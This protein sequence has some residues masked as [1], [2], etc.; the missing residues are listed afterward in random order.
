M[1]SDACRQMLVDGMR[2]IHAATDYRRLRVAQLLTETADPMLD[3]HR[4]VCASLSPEA[5]LSLVLQA[6]AHGVLPAVARNLSTLFAA[7]DFATVRAES[8]RRWREAAVHTIML[9]QLAETIL[10]D[11]HGLPVTIVKGRAFAEDIYPHASLRG[12]TD[13]D[14]LAAPA[15]LEPLAEILRQHG[16]RFADWDHDPARQEFKW[17]RGDDH[18]L[19][20]EIHTNVVHHPE[21]RQSLSLT[22]DDIETMPRAPAAHL[23]VA[24]LHG[25]LHQ[26]ERL[27]QVVDILQAARALATAADEVQFERLVVR[28]GGRLAAVAGLQ[29]A[30]RLFQDPCCHAIAGA[31]G[32]A[33]YA[34][35]ARLLL[36]RGVVTSTMSGTRA[37][38][39][40]RRKS[41]RAL[42]KRGTASP[43]VALQ[44]TTA[45]PGDIGCA[46]ARPS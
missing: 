17:I 46:N 38:H 7:S 21:L 26:Y 23:M 31:I 35:V 27:R 14:L 13:I 20:I 44:A 28:T 11:A 3:T 45:V 24:V 39:S 30:G 6:D 36:D 34:S 43:S 18:A 37:L 10:A 9:R 25:A 19:L 4:D 29:L 41:F 22:Y 8:S 33:R 40:W 32:P 15:A 42:L 16:F 5:A 1:S 12:Y 2:G